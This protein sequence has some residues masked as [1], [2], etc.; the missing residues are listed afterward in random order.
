MRTLYKTNTVFYVDSGS[1]NFTTSNASQYALEFVLKN[2]PAGITLKE[3]TGETLY[4]AYRYLLMDSTTADQATFSLQAKVYA[5]AHPESVL[6]SNA[7]TLTVSNPPQADYNSTEFQGL[8]NVDILIDGVSSKIPASLGTHKLTVATNPANYLADHPNISVSFGCGFGARGFAQNGDTITLTDDGDGIGLGTALTYLYTTLKY[9][10]A[11][12]HNH[13]C[14]VDR[15]I[16]F[17]CD[18]EEH[19]GDPGF[20][21][22][23]G[24]ATGGDYGLGTY[25]LKTHFESWVKTA[26]NDSDYTFKCLFNDTTIP[27]GLSLSYGGLNEDIVLTVP[28]SLKKQVAYS[29]SA[30][31]ISKADSTQVKKASPFYVYGL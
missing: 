3:H 18:E 8:K 1:F 5:T 27:D 26:Y 29:F 14:S 24:S 12:L 30:Y 21:I 16:T 13:F 20:Y 22:L 31:L 17:A 28:S 9:T 15:P 11:T 25:K 4:Y 6:Y 23:D 19:Y 10:D 7:M 2:A